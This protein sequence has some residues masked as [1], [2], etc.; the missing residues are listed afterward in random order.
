MCYC[1]I[2]NQQMRTLLYLLCGIQ[3]LFVILKCHNIIL[4]ALCKY[5][6]WFAVGFCTWIWKRWKYMKV[7]FFF[8][9]CYINIMLLFATCYLM[10]Y[11]FFDFD[12]IYITLWLYY[13]SVNL[14]HCKSFFLLV[15][16]F[17]IYLV[18]SKLTP[19]W[20]DLEN[21]PLLTYLWYLFCS[22]RKMRVILY[23][24]FGLKFYV[25]FLCSLVITLEHH[26]INRVLRA[27]L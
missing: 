16:I 10:N 4:D 5:V 9:C 12:G 6:P 19:V 26:M 1:S 3:F 7:Q 8:S 11:S 17:H 15:P 27:I 14:I 21:S 2:C 18:S 22:N 13:S 23:R 24:L 20:Y 25:V